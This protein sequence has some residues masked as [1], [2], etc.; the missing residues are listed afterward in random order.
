MKQRGIGV[1]VGLVAFGVVVP[2]AWAISVSG[3]AYN[4]TETTALTGAS[5]N[6][7]LRVNGGTAST[8]TT[9]SS[10]GTWSFASVTA[11]AGATITIYF[12]GQ[13]D[14]LAGTYTGN[15]V[16]ITDGTTN[17]TGVALMDDHVVLRSDNGATAI[18]ILDVLDY[19]NDQNAAN[20]LFDAEDAAPDTLTLES[21]HELYITATDTFTPGGNVT[22]TGVT[23]GGSIDIQGTWTAAGTESI[24]LGQGTWNVATT[25]VFIAASSTVTLGIY[26]E[27]ITVISGGTDDSHDF[28]NV[29]ISI[30]NAFN[31]F[32]VVTNDMDING[33]LTV[34]GG[35]I[36]PTTNIYLAGNLSVTSTNIGQSTDTG[37][38]IFDGAGLQTIANSGGETDRLVDFQITNSSA[39]GV[40]MDNAVTAGTFI[41]N[42]NSKFDCNGYDLTMK[43]G[44]WTVASS[45]TFITGANTVTFAMDADLITVTTGGTDDSHDFNNVVIAISNAFNNFD[46]VTNDMD[47][48]G[49]LTM[50]GGTFSPTTNVYLAGN[51]TIDDATNVAAETD[52]GDLIFDGAA[53]Q[54][55]SNSVGETDAVAE[56]QIS[57][58]TAS[59]VKL[60]DAVTVTS[61]AINANAL[62]NLNGK[63]YTTATAFTNS[64]TLQLTGDE[65]VTTPTL[66]A[67]STVEYTATSG[68]RAIKGWTYKSLKINGTGG[69]FT[70]PA[71]LAALGENLTVTAGTLDANGQTL[72]VNDNTT[73]NGGTFKTGTNTI[74]FGSV[75]GGDSVTISSGELQIQS[76]STT[77]DIV[78]NAS[79]WTNSGGTITYN[80]ASAISTTL[81]SALSPYYDLTVNSTGSTYTLNGAIVVS[82][83]LTITA[84]TLDTGNGLNYQITVGRNWSNSGTFTARSG[85]VVLNTTTTAALSGAT[86]FY[87]LSS[88]TAGKTLQFTA[89]QT[90]TVS[91]LLTITGAS[92]NQ[93]H[94]HSTSGSQW[95]I[96]HQ[97][98]ESVT[99]AH[100]E[101]SGCDGSS[102]QIT[103]DSSSTDGGGNGS[104]WVF[105]IPVAGVSGGLVGYWPFE[106]MGGTGAG[107]FSGNGNGGTLAGANGLPAWTAGKLGGA[108]YFDGV[109]DKATIG[110]PASGVLDFG[111]GSFSYGAWVYVSATVGSWDMA[112]YKGGSSAG[113]AGYDVELGAS[114]WAADIADATTLK[115]V[116]FSASPILNRW[117]HLMAVVDRTGNQFCAYVDGALVGSC[118]DITGFGSV[119]NAAAAVIGSSGSSYWFGGS[120]DDVRVY[121][122]SL[123]ADEV[124]TLYRAGVAKINASP[125]TSL[126]S[127]LV[128]YWTFDGQDV[129]WA[130]STSEAKDRSGNANHGDA[131]NNTTAAIGRIG[132]ALAFDGSNARVVVTSNTLDDFSVFTYCAWAYPRSHGENSRGR[133]IGKGLTTSGKHL[134]AYGDV[135]N[136]FDFYVN[137]ATT[138]G[139]RITVTNTMTMNAW[140]HV[141]GTYN[142]TDGPKIFVNGVEASYSTNV[143]GVGATLADNGADL[144]IGNRS[145]AVA[146]WDGFLDDVR[147]YNRTLSAEEVRALYQLGTARINSSPTEFLTNGLIGYWTFDGADVSGTSATDRSGNGNTGTLTPGAAGLNRAA[148]RLGQALEFDKT[149]DYVTAGSASVLDNVTQK[150]VC[151]WIFPYSKGELNGSNYYG[152]IASKIGVVDGWAFEI[153]DQDA[154]IFSLYWWQGFASGVTPGYW[155]APNNAVALNAWSH[156]CA[157]YD[158]SSSANDPVLYVNGVSQTPTEYYTPSGSADDDS[159]GNLLMGNLAATTQT[160]DGKIDEVRVYNRLL[161]AE[162]VRALYQAGR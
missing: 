5:Y 159:A 148:G 14:T 108:V 23:N 1:M 127:G 158:R 155:H 19:D 28:N 81:L 130:A 64:G 37:D 88:T 120:I 145:D 62:L 46:V 21:G 95:L 160:F 27:L 85:T 96:N 133:I 89:G 8:T 138:S 40:R 131:Q 90:F 42:A 139:E 105:S 20:L 117:V 103:L 104:C 69:T 151:A 109:D 129:D 79:T 110:D 152:E 43:R 57:N 26:N 102:T 63:N 141:C 83:D 78:K 29:V 45:A 10:D 80:A 22:V 7:A 115:A 39:S 114:V 99:Y 125:T 76:D 3:T 41:M 48:D 142:E 25:G 68:S 92:G 94:V 59:G 16:T 153:A 72:T 91:G 124:R 44:T 17:I 36:S 134:L 34:S 2:S 4:N 13:T 24:T 61:T 56:V 31:N 67:G 156:V 54:T 111:T 77:A 93:I 118:T 33:N 53:L 161:S 86:T 140:Q 136:S 38:L 74:T 97:G 149:D 126:T 119:S 6:V 32:D 87:N 106:E 73:I 65:T 49:N 52:T 100:L 162:E 30:A 146:T 150:T 116:N 9:S 55:I 121:N 11:S 84:G 58:T 123:S 113:N 60:N 70:V 135:T 12:Y 75:A 112:W 50:S 82:R 35:I 101:N 132:Q 137:R 66:N 71:A 128:G 122:R 157:T 143:A 154:G 15:V 98:T 107:D 47:I 144:F 18:T 147:V 51:L